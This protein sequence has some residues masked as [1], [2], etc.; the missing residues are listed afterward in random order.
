MADDVFLPTQPPASQQDWLKRVETVLKGADFDKKLVHM[1]ADAIRIDPLYRKAEGQKP[2]VGRPAGQAWSLMARI[3]HPDAQAANQQALEDLEQGATGLHLVFAHAVNSYGFGLPD[4]PEAVASALEGVMLDVGAELTLDPG[5]HGKAAIQ[6]VASLVKA[7]NVVPATTH[8]RFGLDPLGAWAVTGVAPCPPDQFAKEL[9]KRI[10]ALVDDLR[11]RGY[12]TPLL[13]ADGRIIHAAGGSEAQELAFA[14]GAALFYLRG[15]EAHGI[16][17]EDGRKTLEFRLAADADQILTLAK[18]RALRLLWARIET[19]CGLVPQPIVLSAET[20]WRM[21]TRRDPYVT[22]LRNT[23]AVFAAGLGGANAVTV[24]PFTQALGLPDAFARRMARNTQLVLLE[25]SHLHKVSDPAAGSGGVESLTHALCEKAWALFQES[26]KLGGLDHALQ[27]GSVAAHVGA[28]LAKRNKDVARRKEPITGTSEFPHINE[29]AVA[30]LAP[31]PT[32]SE[33][34]PLPPTR[35]SAAFEALRD[36]SDMALAQ[37]GKRP[38]VFLANL[39]PVS[40][41]TARNQFAKNFFEAGG[42]NSIGDTPHDGFEALLKAYQASGCALVCLC[43]S[44]AVYAEQAVEAAK[45][46]KAAG[47]NILYLAGRP[48]EHE[49]AFKQAGVDDF[50]A[51]GMDM[52][53]FLQNLHRQ[54]GLS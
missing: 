32:P 9:P 4:T 41:F 28:V 54:L 6:A 52:L 37:S 50:I 53:A 3:D 21:Q 24:L 38:S 7:R 29:Q 16:A 44:D 17:L 47:V 27:T 1:T 2:L 15:L 39:G 14:L 5:P 12:E 22:L 48:A 26:E 30:V 45:A 46:L 35:S 13:K 43:S 36:A 19:A 51:A 34:G 31:C 10:S 18:F 8:I 25:E 23:V 11:G 20:A 49:A 33:Q 40:A 42:I